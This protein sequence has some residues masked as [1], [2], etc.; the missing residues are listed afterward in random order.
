M[1]IIPI[2]DRVIN[3]VIRVK[4]FLM[5]VRLAA[6]ASVRRRASSEDKGAQMQITGKPKIQAVG[7]PQ[8]SLCEGLVFTLS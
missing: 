1:T 5:M 2:S 7:G 4:I 6:V 8:K 3:T